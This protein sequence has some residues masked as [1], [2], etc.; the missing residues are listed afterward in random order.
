MLGNKMQASSRDLCV[1][2]GPK[3]N[4]EMV[5]TYVIMAITVGVSFFAWSRPAIQA[6]FMMNPYRIQQRHEYYRF[7]TSGFIHNDHVHLLF[8]MVSLYFF[9][10]S[11]EVKFRAIFGESGPVY[12]IGLYLLALIVSDLPTFFRHKDHPYYNSLGA[13]GAVSAVI[14]ASILLSPLTNVCMLVICLPG[15]I[16]GLLFIVFS[17]YQGRKSADNINHDAHLYGALFGL[18]FCIVMYPYSLRSFFDQ[19]SQWR[20]LE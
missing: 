7:V 2:L 5:I 18:L 17:Y 15:F 14:F 12:F 6:G 9:G 10:E 16:M 13:S 11:T 1:Y 8:N 4:R 20:M 19:V 3:T